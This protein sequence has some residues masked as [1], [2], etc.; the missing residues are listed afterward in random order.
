MD[1]RK[2]TSLNITQTKEM[3]SINQDQYVEALEGPDM[4]GCEHEAIEEVIG[5]EGQTEFRSIKG[6]LARVGQISRPDVVLEV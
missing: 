6:K 2:T 5:Q 1:W 4:E 3:I